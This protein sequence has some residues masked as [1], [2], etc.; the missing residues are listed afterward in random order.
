[1]LASTR[2][3]GT[4]MPKYIKLQTHPHPHGKK[5]A[6]SFPYKHTQHSLIKLWPF[7]SEVDCT[8]VHS[9]YPLVHLF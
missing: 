4:R 7:K 8:E 5:H 9:L 3:V 1:M 6:S 2:L